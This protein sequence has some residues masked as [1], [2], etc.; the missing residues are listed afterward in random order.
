MM[1]SQLSRPMFLLPQRLRRRPIDP[2][3]GWHQL[4]FQSRR[5]TRRKK[6]IPTP[7]IQYYND[8]QKAMQEQ[9]TRAEINAK[10]DKIA[11][12]KKEIADLKQQL[13]DLEDQLRSAGGDPGWAR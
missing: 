1:T 7:D 8:P 12:K 10:N 5:T 3:A 6:K 4:K 9:Y 2:T 13:S 11:E